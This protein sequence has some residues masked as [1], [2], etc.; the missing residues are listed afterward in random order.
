MNSLTKEIAEETIKRWAPMMRIADWEIDFAFATELEIKERAKK[1][2][3]VAICTRNRLLKQA[4][5][6]LNPQHPDAQADWQ[7]VLA[8]EMFHVVTDDFQ[9][10]A[11]CCL[12]FVPEE[13]HE[14]LLNQLDMY[15]ERMV[16]DLAAGFVAALRQVDIP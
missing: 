16:E 13:A 9:Y 7:R 5:I 14:T 6:E 2:G 11:D 12:D 15:Y 8:H 4:L 3:C 1:N 10:H